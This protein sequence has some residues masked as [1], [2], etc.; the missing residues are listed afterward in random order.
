[1]AILKNL[2][3]VVKVPFED[4]SFLKAFGEA[5]NPKRNYQKEMAEN[6][7]KIKEELQK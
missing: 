3:D 5:I 1:M 4:N 7:K 2:T 6:L